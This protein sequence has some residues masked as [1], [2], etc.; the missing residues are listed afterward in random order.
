MKLAFRFS[1]NYADGLG[2]AGV[3]AR[4]LRRPAEGIRASGLLHHKLAHR[5][6]ET[7]RRDAGGKRPGRS[8]SP[9]SAAL[10]WLRACLLA[11][12]ALCIANLDANA[13]P[14]DGHI[15]ILLVTGMDYPGHHWRETAPVLA[16]ALRKDS[17]LEVFTVEDPHFLDSDALASYDAVIL[18]WQNW[19]QPGPGQKA[20]ENLRHFVAGGKGLVLVHFACGAWHDE[21]PEFVKIAGRVWYGSNG[22]Q[23]DPY[24]PFRVEIAQPENPIVAGLGDFD[25]QDELYTCL[26]GDTPIEIL[27]QAKSKVDGKYYPMALTAHYGQGRT[28]LCTLGHDATSFSSEKVQEL[29]R[30]GCAWSGGL[31]PIGH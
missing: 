26:I 3:L 16:Q 30:R 10:F 7:S 2:S 27:A 19:Q 25:T 28:F 20:R 29:Y 13:A 11:A 9:V 1:R 8:R 5:E 17:R 6:P 24:G 14:A 12:L 18:F 4:G 22:R 23:H 15:R 31:P 21:W